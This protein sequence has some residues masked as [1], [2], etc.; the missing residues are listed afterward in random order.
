MDA[1]YAVQSPRLL[2]SRLLLHLYC[3]PRFP[4]TELFG[5]FSSTFIKC[6]SYW[7]SVTLDC[8]QVSS[9][10]LTPASDLAAMFSTASLKSSVKPT[11]DASPAVP[12][13]FKTPSRLESLLLCCS[14]FNIFVQACKQCKQEGCQ[15]SWIHGH[16]L[17]SQVGYLAFS[18]LWNGANL[19]LIEWSLRVDHA[20]NAN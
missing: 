13:A 5:H 17:S 1:G 4:C 8:H 3:R 19:N 10:V 11:Q 15:W 9:E 16:L 18:I 20:T 14:N 2:R 6:N 7:P 12:K